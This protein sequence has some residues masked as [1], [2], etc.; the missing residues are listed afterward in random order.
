[1]RA[2]RVDAATMRQ[3]LLRGT[4]E[5]LPQREQ[6]QEIRARVAKEQVRLVGRLGL[7]QW[8]LA[9]VGHG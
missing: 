6:R 2:T 8:A 4:L 1:M 5:E 7:A 9:R 3:R